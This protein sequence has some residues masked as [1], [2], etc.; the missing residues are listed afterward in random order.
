[1][2][3]KV[4]VCAP[5]WNPPAKD[6]WLHNRGRKMNG[7]WLTPANNNIYKDTIT[8]NNN[9]DNNNNNHNHLVSGS[10]RFTQSVDSLR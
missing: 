2:N 1:M 5:L 10:T 4:P 3:N 6:F 7:E 8:Y 9:N